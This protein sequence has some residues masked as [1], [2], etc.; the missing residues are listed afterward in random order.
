MSA[1][2][3]DVV[4]IPHDNPTAID[5]ASSKKDSE[6]NSE[7]SKPAPRPHRL[8]FALV[9]V[10]LL[11]VAVGIAIFLAVRLNADSKKRESE[12]P[13]PSP[14]V[15]F[16]NLLRDTDFEG[17]VKLMRTS[18]DPG[19]TDRG[20]PT[21]RRMASE[22]E[23]FIDDI[24]LTSNIS[25]VYNYS[26]VR[27]FRQGSVVVMF[28]SKLLVR[29]SLATDDLKLKHDRI[30]SNP[31][32][33]LQ[34]FR[35]GMAILALRQDVSLP[36]GDI[37]VDSLRAGTITDT[38]TAKE[39]TTESTTSKTTT[40]ASEN[41]RCGEVRSLPGGSRIVNGRPTD[42][43]EYPW[44]VS[45][46][47]KHID[48]NACGGS[49]IDSLHVLTAAHC[50][51][52]Y[53]DNEYGR[54]ESEGV[55]VIAGKHEYETYKATDQEQRATI[56]KV[57]MHQDYD[58]V[59]D[60]SF[61]DIALIRLASPLTFN[62][63]VAP[64]CLPRVD[65]Q[66]P[67]QCVAA[68]WGTTTEGDTD[69]PVVLQAVTL[70]AYNQTECK[71]VFE[72][73]WR[74]GSGAS[75]ED[76]GYYLNEGVM[77]ASNF[78]HG[79]GDTCQRGEDGRRQYT[80]YG[81]VSWGN[82]CGEP[83]KPGFYTYVPHYLDWIENIAK[84][85]V[86][87]W[88][89]QSFCLQLI[90][91]SVIPRQSAVCSLLESTIDCMQ[92]LDQTG[93]CPRYKT[94]RQL[95]EYLSSQNSQGETGSNLWLTASTECPDSTQRDACENPQLLMT[96]AE[97]FCNLTAD[98]STAHL[99]LRVIPSVGQCVTD[100]IVKYL[101]NCS[102]EQVA[103]QLAAASDVLQRRDQLCSEYCPDFQPYGCLDVYSTQFMRDFLE[104]A[105]SESLCRLAFYK[106]ARCLRS[107]LQLIGRPCEENK[108]RLS[109]SDYFGMDS[110]MFNLCDAAYPE[111]REEPP[112]CEN[113]A[114]L[115]TLCNSSCQ[116]RLSGDPDRCSELEQ[117][118]T[119]VT[120]ELRRYGLYCPHEL[121]VEHL[122][123][124][125]SC[126]VTDDT[127]RDP[128][129][130][131]CS[132]LAAANAMSELA[133][134]YCDVIINKL[135]ITWHSGSGCSI[136]TDL[137]TCL[138]SVANYEGYLCTE[139]DVATLTLSMPQFPVDNISDK[140]TSCA[141]S[142][143]SE[144]ELLENDL[145]EDPHMARLYGDYS[146]APS[147]QAV[148]ESSRDTFC[149]KPTY[150]YPSFGEGTVPI[151]LDE[152][153]CTGLE[154]NLLDCVHVGVGNHDCSHIEDAGLQV[155]AHQILETP[156]CSRQLRLKKLTEYVDISQSGLPS[157]HH[158]TV[159]STSLP[160]IHNAGVTFDMPPACKDSVTV[161]A[162]MTQC[163]PVDSC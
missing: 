151:L 137:L 118:V 5:T 121:V 56:A 6:K 125:L 135:N 96:I 123:L 14:R 127:D 82:G 86:D 157:W 1:S 44:L 85:I 9:L 147:L 138:T 15:Y 27:E 36:P 71:R 43:G 2:P 7:A 139:Q 3:G 91:Q 16:S 159:P 54:V 152:L 11:C 72:D 30:T 34:A 68:G 158:V 26:V 149:E 17:S 163:E 136:L 40:T 130:M 88:C 132:G 19:L 25:D 81:V 62:S 10:A 102:V 140:L 61:N 28:Q 87:K 64:V 117:Y 33:W 35:E 66:V 37:N 39:T 70:Q 67:Q 156:H 24:F 100:V 48:M 129:S 60:T 160:K 142:P 126:N 29:Q 73:V 153:E 115:D 162:A 21:F 154:T 99:C 105:S 119:E 13:V 90:E 104:E 49:I 146:C 92:A 65:T 89:V 12:S 50:F 76:I 83:G 150:K 101:G 133:L 69:L 155:K 98:S 161:A 22:K 128:P 108:L 111:L 124:A 122:G 42:Y 52:D 148:V 32:A 51:E 84:P 120:E 38:T 134:S 93:L 143:S 77:C 20:S 59:S 46:W 103:P 144:L 41:F 79:G 75:L 58:P 97:N 47:N 45:L 131:Q 145:C 114:L 110:S 74:L 31:A 141:I 4:L 53:I 23:L 80:Q 55:V 57:Y 95:A 112:A 106:S 107:K 8:W 94:R 63:R 78:T 113:P 18:W 116:H 109:V